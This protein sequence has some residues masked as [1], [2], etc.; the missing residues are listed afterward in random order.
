[1]KNSVDNNS[2][3][4]HV[5]FRLIVCTL[6]LLFGIGG[7]VA[8][9]SLKKPPAEAKNGE[10]PL[11]V[12]VMQ[13]GAEAV[14]VVITGYGQVRPVKEV[15]M[16]AEVAGQVTAVHPRLRAGE[17]IA[18]GDL[19]F[20]IDTRNYE[21]AA[22]QARAE[23]DQSLSL[24]NRLE[25]QAVVDAE[26][27]K[28]LM[29]SRELA[30]A[31]YE[32]IRMLFEQHGVGTRSGVDR[33]EQAFNAAVDQSDQMALA[34]SL[35]PLRIKEAQSALA[36]AR[37]RLSQAQT[38][39]QRCRVVAPFNG[40]IKAVT[41]EQGQY[42]SP[43][44]GLLILADDTLLEIHVPLDSRDVGQWI[45]FDESGDART[46]GWFESLQP[47][48]CVVRW[49]EAPRE[50]VAEG[51]LHRV[52]HFDPKTRTITVAVQI[53]G[54]GAFQ[55]GRLPLVEGMFCEVE[56]PG[57]TLPRA[58]RIPRQAVGFRGTLFT[59]VGGR[60]K[61]VEVQVARENGDDVLVVG[62]L[63]EG[64]TVITTRLVD[65]LEGALI[66]IVPAA[67]SINEAGSR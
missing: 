19:L 10:R 30:A 14:Q 52:V 5:R 51:I 42:V 7:Y 46:G 67:V 60:L 1:M 58:F 2:K 41:I 66:E 22:T 12:T 8:L 27:L 47:V 11:K 53:S 26:R 29:R 49:T 37:A 24:L 35:N 28:T 39:L 61:T 57:R 36:A 15:P 40:R 63:E 38:N 56:I 6:L 20:Q 4:S 64:D 23:V 34:V 65:P 13:A 25:K 43:G 33:A 21:A 62:G 44:Q 48:A 32:R 55:R 17:Q 3:P 59:V 9:A 45:G 54:A 18:E 50:H 31:E 16:A